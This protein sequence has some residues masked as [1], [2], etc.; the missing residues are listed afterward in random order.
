MYRIIILA[1]VLVVFALLASC[2]GGASDP[3]A[4]ISC[5][6]NG[7]TPT[8]AYKRLYQ[9]VKAKN[10]EAIKAE[11]TKE[12]VAMG[13]FMAQRFKKT[14]AESYENGLT[15]TTFSP[16]LPDIRDERVNCNMGAVEIW[17]SSEQKWDDVPFMLEDG[18]WKLAFGEGFKG[19]F[20]SPGKGIATKEAE[21]ANAARGNILIPANA[22]NANK[23]IIIH[24]SAN[25]ATPPPVA[26]NRNRPTTK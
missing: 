19:S 22:V 20:K 24:N 26:T 2:G 17:N 11:L 10:T 23:P 1:S 15:S 14:P 8:A 4:T 5:E 9:A 21:A 25:A 12:S 18:K 3:V 13:E 6:A 16:T 7:D